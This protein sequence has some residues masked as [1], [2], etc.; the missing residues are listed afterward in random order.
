MLRRLS[1]MFT[2]A[3]LAACSSSVG[4]SD[5]SLPDVATTDAVALPS[6]A[7]SLPTDA[8]TPTDAITPYTRENTAWSCPP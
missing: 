8:V 4:A 1:P 5:A 2:V 7:V 6:D 3:L